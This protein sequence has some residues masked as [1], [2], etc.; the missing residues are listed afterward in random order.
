MSVLHVVLIAGSVIEMCIVPVGSN[1]ADAT[2]GPLKSTIRKQVPNV[3]NARYGTI[4]ASSS[5]VN[6]VLPIISGVAIDYFGATPGSIISSCFILVG[7]LIRA[8][9]GRSASFRT[10]VCSVSESY[11]Q[12]RLTDRPEFTAFWL[13]RS[14]LG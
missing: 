6:A 2:L 8:V 5:L 10:S 9:G 13:V 11:W 4:A 1:Y 12:Q 14:S 7:T 3:S